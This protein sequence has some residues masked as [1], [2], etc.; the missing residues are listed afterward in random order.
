MWVQENFLCSFMPFEFLIFLWYWNRIA[1]L[2]VSFVTVIAPRKP[3]AFF[4][5]PRGMQLKHPPW[6]VNNE[7]MYKQPAKP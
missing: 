2:A 6:H 1:L 4:T 7:K 3:D 5:Y